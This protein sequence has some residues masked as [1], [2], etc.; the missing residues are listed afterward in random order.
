MCCDL[1]DHSYTVPLQLKSLSPAVSEPVNESLP[2][3]DLED[4]RPMISEVDQV[5]TRIDKSLDSGFNNGT[6]SPSVRSLF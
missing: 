3:L 2:D 5:E 6:G 1:L 4:G